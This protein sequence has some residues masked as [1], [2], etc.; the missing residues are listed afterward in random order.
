[1]SSL[2]SPKLNRNSRQVGI[3]GGLTPEASSNFLATVATRGLRDQQRSLRGGFADETQGPIGISSREGPTTQ[4][5]GILLQQGLS[6]SQ[7]EATIDL[8]AL[9]EAGEA[10]SAEADGQEVLIQQSSLEGLLAPAS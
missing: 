10:E 3:T 6:V 1:M 8:E 4:P 9:E 7:P 2:S 5:I